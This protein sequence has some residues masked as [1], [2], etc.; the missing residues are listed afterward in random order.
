MSLKSKKNLILFKSVN[1]EFKNYQKIEKNFSI[2]SVNSFKD[3]NKINKKIK[4]NVVAIYCSQKYNYN[5]NLKVFKNLKFLLSSTTA[6]TFIDSK[7]CIKKKI[8]IISLEKETNFLK[9]ITP[10][11]EH[12]FG[13][14]LMISRNYIQAIRSIENDKKFDRSPF[15]GIKMLSRSALGIVGYGRLG[16]I[17]KKIAVGFGMKVYHADI[18]EKN[19]KIKL[20]KIFSNSDFVSLH[21]PHLNNEGFFSSNNIKISKPFFLIN[22][23]RGE[24]IDEKFLIKSLKN[25]KI[26]GYATD[27]LKEEFDPNFKLKKNLLFKHIHKYN[28]IITP[29]IGGSTKDAWV[30]T[31]KRIIDKFLKYYN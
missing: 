25:K 31:Q 23:S 21:I 14:I 24:I 9:K 15:A 27:V 17:V 3:I 4:D 12:V 5:S 28:I 7:Y 13:L 26:L 16:R 6:T 22:T 30:L 2:I 18:K 11:A 10:T 19:F 1:L 29:H 20:K 8:K